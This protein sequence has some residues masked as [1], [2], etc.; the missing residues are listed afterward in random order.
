MDER[1]EKLKVRL[2]IIGAVAFVVAILVI[3]AFGIAARQ[4]E[5][6]QNI[7]NDNSD[8]SSKPTDEVIPTG[9]QDSFYRMMAYFLHGNAEATIVHQEPYDLNKSTTYFYN[10]IVKRGKEA[11]EFLKYA[12]EFMTEYDESNVSEVEY[13]RRSEYMDVLRKRVEAIEVVLKDVPNYSKDYVYSYIAGYGFDAMKKKM[14]DEYYPY[15]NANDSRIIG[16]YTQNLVARDNMLLSIY[17]IAQSEGCLKSTSWKDGDKVL[18]SKEVFECAE[19]SGSGP[20]VKKLES[21]YET[22]DSSATSEL[23]STLY[24]AAQAMFTVRDEMEA[25]R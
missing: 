19:K 24:S 14:T 3:S 6:Q 15:S 21:G 17:Q 9:T 22:Y 11:D 13:D 4:R 25:S 10:L 12:D 1:K 23:R 18:D 7:V 5:Q 16:T 8:P 2:V 20:K